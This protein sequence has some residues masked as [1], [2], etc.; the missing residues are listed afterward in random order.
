MPTTDPCIIIQGFLESSTS[1]P[2]EGVA[3]DL[4]QFQKLLNEMLQPTDVTVLITFRLGSRTNAASQTR[5]RLL[6]IVLATLTDEETPTLEGVL[7]TETIVWNELL[8]LEESTSSGPGAMPAKLL[9][10]LAPQMFKPIALIFQTSFF[11]GCLPSDWK[12]ATITLLFR[13][14][15]RAS[16]NN[17]RPVSLTSICCKIMEKSIN[18]A[19]MQF[20]EQHHLLSDAQH[21]LRSG[22]SCLTNVP[23]AL[24]R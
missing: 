10:E 6:K 22:R 24:E 13:G 18:K 17:Y 4:E 16:V 9:K 20:H 1:V 5:P 23:F 2:T 21:G 11:T 7:L 3:A 8:N 12:S 15:S 19:L 14:G